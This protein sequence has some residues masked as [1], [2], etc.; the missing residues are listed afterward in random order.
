MSRVQQS[1]ARQVV[2]FPD[3]P[4]RLNAHINSLRGQE[5]GWGEFDCVLFAAGAVQA[6]TGWDP[7]APWRGQWSD[8]GSAYRMM[9]EVGRGGRAIN[10][11]ALYRAMVYTLGSSI[12]GQRGKRGDIAYF[13]GNCGV[14]VGTH[15]LFLT[16]PSVS[17]TGIGAMGI[18]AI[19][20][21]FP[22]GW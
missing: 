9:E 16:E 3:W 6:I 2:R 1:W 21:A 22:I 4:K 18:R 20:R 14:I 10:G 7:I 19:E 11:S 13:E 5:F 17:M 15:A 12:R 8:E